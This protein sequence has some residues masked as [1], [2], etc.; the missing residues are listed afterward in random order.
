LSLR[1]N[2]VHEP[3]GYNVLTPV[4][5]TKQQNQTLTNKGRVSLVAY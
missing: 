1:Q 3:D 2:I 4:T 5:V